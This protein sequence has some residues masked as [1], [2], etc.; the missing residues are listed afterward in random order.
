MAY[1]LVYVK[2]VKNKRVPGFSRMTDENVGGLIPFV[3]VLNSG[4]G[5]VHFF[6]S[7]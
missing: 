2:K 6:S 7:V 1:S 4:L 5:V 3:E